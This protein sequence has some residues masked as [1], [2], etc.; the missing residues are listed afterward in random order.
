MTDLVEPLE[1]LSAKAN[2]VI[3][4]PMLHVLTGGLGTADLIVAG[5]TPD[6]A[7][8][9]VIESD[10]KTN[11]PPKTVRIGKRNPDKKKMLVLGPGDTRINVVDDAAY[12]VGE[13]QPRAYRALEL[14]DLGDDRVGAINVVREK[15]TFRLQESVGTTDT[16]YVLAQPVTATATPKSKNLLATGSSGSDGL[17]LRPAFGRREGGG[18][19]DAR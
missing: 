11:T 18:S 19:G 10:P 7:T 1:R 6:R 9:V 5:L 17:R 2:E 16:T 12:A 14:F 8:T 4:R 13:R 3:D 15:E